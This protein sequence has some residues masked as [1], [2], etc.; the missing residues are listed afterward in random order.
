L[1]KPSTIQD[2][3]ALRVDPGYLPG[4][5]IAITGASGNVGTALVRTLSAHGHDVIGIARRPPAS[6]SPYAVA[7]WHA[8]DLTADDAA[9][10]LAAAFEGAD[11]VVHLA[12]AFQPTHDREYTERLDVGGTERVIEATLAAGV[13]HLVHQS[14]LGAYSPAPH[15]DRPVPETWARRGITTSP[16]S[17][18]KVA[19]EGILDDTLV[20]HPDLIIARTRPVLIGQRLS[21]SGLLRYA[22]PA[23]VPSAALRRVPLLPV[24]GRLRLQFV[25][26]EDVATAIRLIVEQH[27]GGAFNLAADDV[28]PV[29]A[30]A[31]AL[32]GRHLHVPL[33]VLRRLADLSWRAHLQQVDVGWLD[34]AY[35]APLLDSTR[36]RVEL[37]WS[38]QHRSADVLAEVLDGMRMAAYDDTPILRP[39]RVREGVVRALR[40][41]PVARRHRP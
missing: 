1:I 32:G 29:E 36:A 41:E 12:W 15:D 40:G 38:P 9:G 37:G 18:H 11:A 23:L 35:Q 3:P 22:V 7:R 31:R 19:A 34:M 25:H 10:S 26:A 39:R 14:S 5:R 17:R 4:M 16:Y 33:P 8:V 30:I 6:D 2:I 27:R 13:P 24:D 20:R 28:V 21:G